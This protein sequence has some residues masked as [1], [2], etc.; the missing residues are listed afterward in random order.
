VPL[1]G[2]KGAAKRDIIQYVVDP[3]IAYNDVCRLH[4]NVLYRDLV[5]LN[6]AD[7]LRS[8]LVR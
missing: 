3:S 1:I 6:A 2:Y 8:K 4:W 5:D 7:D